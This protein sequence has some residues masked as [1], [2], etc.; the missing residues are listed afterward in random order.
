MQHRT[1][2]ALLGLAITAVTAGAVAYAAGSSEPNDALAISTAKVSLA[3]A[4]AAAE[5]HVGG[6]ASRA[7]FEHSK[8]QGWHYEVEVAGAAQVYD[9]VVDADRGTVISAVE[10]RADRGGDH[11]EDD[12]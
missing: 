11:D 6:R 7:E 12:D 3:Q 10:D 4:V 8:A 1:G 5:Q 9:V 2:W